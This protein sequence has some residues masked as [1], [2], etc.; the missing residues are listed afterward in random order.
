MLTKMFY[1]IALGFLKRKLY[2]VNAGMELLSR[3]VLVTS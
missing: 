2:S 3:L 1:N